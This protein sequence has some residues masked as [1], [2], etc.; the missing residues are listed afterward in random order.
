[1][2]CLIIFFDDPFLNLHDFLCAWRA[3]DAKELIF[4]LKSDGQQFLKLSR[5]H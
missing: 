5:P 4:E 1:M 3:R 2:G